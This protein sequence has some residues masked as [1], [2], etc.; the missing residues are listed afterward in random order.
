MRKLLHPASTLE[1][2]IQALAANCSFF[3]NAITGE[4]PF[5][6]P[7]RLFYLNL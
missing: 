6:Y 2:R 3:V 4:L 7:K 1:S 5:W